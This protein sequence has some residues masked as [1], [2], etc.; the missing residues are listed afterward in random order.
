MANYFEI[1]SPRKRQNFNSI[2][3]VRSKTLNGSQEASVS[4][5]SPKAEALARTSERLQAFRDDP[6]TQAEGRFTALGGRGLSVSLPESDR[7]TKASVMGGIT[8]V[9][10]TTALFVAL[11]TFGAGM[12]FGGEFVGNIVEGFGISENSPLGFLAKILF[13][14]GAAGAAGSAGAVAVAAIAALIGGLLL[15]GPLFKRMRRHM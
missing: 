5:A 6:N 1:D 8:K 15:F 9:A 4:L 2:D 3:A 12:L 14:L 11:A 13:I 7:T 10:L